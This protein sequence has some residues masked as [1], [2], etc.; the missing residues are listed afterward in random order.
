MHVLS[1]KASLRFNEKWRAR[2]RNIYSES[3]KS[4]SNPTK[5]FTHESLHIA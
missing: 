1:S 2:A 4:T 5:L 3:R